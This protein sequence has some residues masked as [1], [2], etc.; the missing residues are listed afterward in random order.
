[1]HDSFE[2]HKLKASDP[3]NQFQ[4][5]PIVSDQITKDGLGVVWRELNA[6]LTADVPGDVV[7][8]GCYAGTTSVFIRRLPNQYA[9][10]AAFHAYDSFDGLPEKSPQDNNAAGIDFSAGKLYVSKQDFLKVF[11]GAGLQPP[12]IHK[13]WFSDMREQ[14][15]PEQIAFAFLDGDFYGSIIDSLRLVWPRLADDGVV[16]VDDY[17]RETLPGV[18]R[19]LRDYFG[20]KL[21]VLQASHNIAVIHKARQGK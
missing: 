15:V 21:P 11:R 14:D 10:S 19:A 7:E 9:S 5:F 16:L 20:G 3:K 17:Q 13:G 4:G 2:E 18:E 8:F 6:V 1:M 12:V